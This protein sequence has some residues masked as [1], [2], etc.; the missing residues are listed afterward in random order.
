MRNLR[1]PRYSLRPLVLGPTLLLLAVASGS[2]AMAGSARSLR[3]PALSISNPS[4]AE[5]AGAAVFVVRLSRRS[6]KPVTVRYATADISATA[7]SDYQRSA[8]SLTFKRGERTK[9]ISVRVLDE[10]IAEDDETFGVVLSR[11][12]NARLT[13]AEGVAEILASD[14]P[15]TFT[16]TAVLANAGSSAR[17]NATLTF[18]AANATASFTITVADAPDDPAFVN[19]RSTKDGG[20][21]VNL[22]PPLPPRNGTVSGLVNFPRKMIIDIRQNPA[23]YYVEIHFGRSFSSSIFGTLKI[24]G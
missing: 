13:V 5:E 11:A 22:F 2:P 9:S 10:G 15:P 12:K 21:F 8:G 17:G 14:L 19:L 7:G 1:G 3:P 23:A 24:T 6:P 4:V 18:A 20:V 16:A